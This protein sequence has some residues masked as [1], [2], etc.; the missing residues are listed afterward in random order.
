MENPSETM[1]LPYFPRENTRFNGPG[2]KGKYP[3]SLQETEL[4]LDHEQASHHNGRQSAQSRISTL[5]KQA[6]YRYR[7]KV[8]FLIL[9]DIPIREEEA[10]SHWWEKA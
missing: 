6:A 1:R 4:D 2:A 5:S 8:L 7:N 9:A 3:S 10:V